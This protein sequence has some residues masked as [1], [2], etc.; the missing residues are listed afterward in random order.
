[1]PRR[2]FIMRK[3]LILDETVEALRQCGIN[4]SVTVNRRGHY[5][6]EWRNRN[7]E[8]RT[9]VAARAHGNGCDWRAARNQR[10]IVRRMLQAEGYLS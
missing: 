9:V 6:I 10:S 8:L 3:Q 5:R 7:G 2:F 1:M 4:P